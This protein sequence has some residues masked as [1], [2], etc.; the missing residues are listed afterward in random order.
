MSDDTD[1]LCI[2]GHHRSQHLEAP[3]MCADC[4]RENRDGAFHAFE[5]GPI[6]VG[7]PDQRALDPEMIRQLTDA[8]ARHL[9]LPPE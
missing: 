9:R 1:E 5:A 8:A 6:M 4:A 3:R 2:C 7:G